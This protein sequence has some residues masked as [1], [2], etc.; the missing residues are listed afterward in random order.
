[1]D[2]RKQKTRQAIESAF[3]RLRQDRTPEQISVT[4][5]SRLAKISKATFYLHYRDV[6]DLSE[7][8]QKAAIRRVLERIEGVDSA[9]ECWPEFAQKMLQAVEQ[10]SESLT[11]LFSGS[12]LAMFPMLL[13]DQLRECIL[14][15]SPELKEDTE[16][17]IRLTYHIQ[18]SYHTYIRHTHRTDIQQILDIIRDIHKKSGVS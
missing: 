10:D 1:M 6:Y 13:E 16:L 9:L 14:K 2:L 12:Q 8:L 5:L 17:S 3:L 11:V 15:H 7:T 18:G 4:E